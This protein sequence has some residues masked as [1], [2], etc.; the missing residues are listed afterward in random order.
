MNPRRSFP[1][2]R[3]KVRCTQCHARL[4]DRVYDGERKDCKWLLHYKK[5]RVN[6]T[7]AWMVITCASCNTSHWIDAEKGILKSKRHPYIYDNYD[8]RV[9]TQTSSFA[10]VSQS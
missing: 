10:D 5:S 9:Q 1:S 3:I 2:E 7:T 8:G 6:I 4:C